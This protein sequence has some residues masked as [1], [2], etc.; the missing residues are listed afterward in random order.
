MTRRLN[1][2]E[3]GARHVPGEKRG[4]AFKKRKWGTVKAELRK[5]EAKA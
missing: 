5:K 2:A 1:Y 3:K 4:H